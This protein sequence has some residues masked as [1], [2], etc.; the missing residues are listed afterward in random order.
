MARP[1]QFD[2][3]VAVATAMDVFWSKGYATTTPADLV[4]ALGIGKGSLYN[5]FDSKRSLFERALRLYGDRRVAGLKA[6][7]E[8]P[9][10][11]KPRLEAAL[12]QLANRQASAGAVRGCLAVNS[13]SEFAEHDEDLRGVVQQ[14]FERMEQV[15]RRAVERGQKTGEFS[16]ATDAGS[17]ASLLLAS[18]LGMSVLAKAGAGAR[19]LQRVTRAIM[20][21]M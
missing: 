4:D 20:A 19:R 16:R 14:I 15:I 12:Q 5:A 1:K 9:G 2:P 21:A 10:L 3:D 6:A 17:V 11:L 7:L 8:G 13:A 18:M